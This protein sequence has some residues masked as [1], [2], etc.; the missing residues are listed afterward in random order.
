MPD[1]ARPRM[2]WA[3]SRGGVEYRY[4]SDAYVDVLVFCVSS[5]SLWFSDPAHPHATTGEKGG[6][7]MLLRVKP[8]SFR[9]S[10]GI[11]HDELQ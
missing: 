10:L 6:K 3:R 11:A 2:I 9:T 7:P 5:P 8:E 1:F 4:Y